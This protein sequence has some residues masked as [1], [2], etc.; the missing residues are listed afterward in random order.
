MKNYWL[1][2]ALKR[3]N[4]RSSLIATLFPILGIGF[5]ATV[6]IVVLAVMN[7]F[8]RGYIDTVLEV[9]SAH[10]RLEGK[11]NDLEEIEKTSKHKSF[12]I[13]REEQVLLQGKRGNQST[14]MIRSIEKDVLLK[15]AGFKNTVK[16][17]KGK[18]DIEGFSDEKAPKIILGYELAKR[19]SIKVGDDVQVLATSGTIETDL[20][21][22]NLN[23]LVTGFFKTGYYEIDSSFA[24][25]DLNNSSLLFGEGS[26]YFANVK[27]NNENK[28]MVYINEITKKNNEIKALSWREYNRAFFGA[29]RIEKNVMMLL[30]VLIFLVVGVNIYNGMRRAIYEKREE[31][32]VLLSMGAKPTDIKN[33]FVLSGFITGILGSCFGLIMGLLLSLNIN[34]IFS[35]IESIVTLIMRVG[36]ILIEGTRADAFAIF[37]TSYFYMD[38]VPVRLFFLEIFFVFLFG[39]CSATFASLIATK[40]MT[41]IQPA[42]ILRYE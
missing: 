39:L 34:K 24:F 29:L 41:E 23:L 38:K 19:L 27:L 7:G 12:V 10:I 33:I 28:D 17:E 8:Q 32:A 20:F 31:I 30:I 14:A 36:S 2:F 25:I 9:S 6:L 1:F 16:I 13:F 22:E 40:K 4:V 15:D 26:T 18:F 42:E 11:K 37:N 5:G 3:F 21:P 35:F